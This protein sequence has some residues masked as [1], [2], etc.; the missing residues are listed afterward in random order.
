MLT[1]LRQLDEEPSATRRKSSK[2]SSAVRGARVARRHCRRSRALTKEMLMSNRK[3]KSLVFVSLSIF[4]SLGVACG[5]AA[6]PEAGG[7][8]DDAD[9]VAAF[10]SQGLT[11][12]AKMKDRVTGHFEREG[13]FLDFDFYREGAKH[14]AV[15]KRKGGEPLFESRLEDGIDTM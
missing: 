6:A 3:T 14:I 8:D 13:V 9:P 5:G 4:A 1:N 7:N 11:I 10:S 2:K 15:L 12:D